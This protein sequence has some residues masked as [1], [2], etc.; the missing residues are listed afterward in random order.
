MVKAYLGQNLKRYSEGVLKKGATTLLKSI[1]P[2]LMEKT[3]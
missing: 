2:Q 3:E 1:L